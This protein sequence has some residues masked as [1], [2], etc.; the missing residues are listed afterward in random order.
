MSNKEQVRKVMDAYARRDR[1]LFVPGS[2]HER[3]YGPFYSVARAWRF[4]FGRDPSDDEI[5]AREAANWSVRPMTDINS[6]A[7]IE[8][9]TPAAHP[10]VTAPVPDNSQHGAGHTQCEASDTLQPKQP[11]EGLKVIQPLKGLHPNCTPPCGICE[12]DEW[13]KQFLAS[14]VDPVDGI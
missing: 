2:D 11:I 13:E 8:K 4:L 14:G 10:A 12:P 1:S 3:A 7:A 5:A 9:Q 6:A